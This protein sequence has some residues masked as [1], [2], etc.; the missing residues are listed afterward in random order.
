M[1]LINRSIPLKEST[2]RKSYVHIYPHSRENT[3]RQNVPTSISGP[4]AAE[5]IL[6]IIT[7][8]LL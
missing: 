8:T 1:S 7:L 3:F 4:F 6:I 2:F 5:T